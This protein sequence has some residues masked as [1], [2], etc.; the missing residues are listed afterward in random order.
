MIA[1]R[2]RLARECR[3]LGERA[4]QT[5]IRMRQV[6]AQ[7]AADVARAAIVLREAAYRIGRATLEGGSLSWRPGDDR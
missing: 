1:L 5:S 6:D 3:D 2:R 7:T 4:Q